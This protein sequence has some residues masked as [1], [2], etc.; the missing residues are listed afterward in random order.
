MP[1]PPAELVSQISE[2]KDEFYR[3]SVDHPWLCLYVPTLG[4]AREQPFLGEKAPSRYG[5]NEWMF[6]DPHTGRTRKVLIAW[7]VD[8]PK[9]GDRMA[10][11]DHV[12][13]LTHQAED[14]LKRVLKYDSQIS[15]EEQ[16]E[17]REWEIRKRG[18]G[19]VQWICYSTVVRYFSRIENYRQIAASALLSL[20]EKCRRP[21]TTAKARGQASAGRG[22][23]RRTEET[24]ARQKEIA[25]GWE[26][27]YES[28]AWV[29]PRNRG[30][31]TAKQ[32]FCKSEGID[33][34]TLETAL[35]QNR[36]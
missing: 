11:V 17:I 25:D 9:D 1:P 20:K 4:N 27:Y 29:E 33:L 36:R 22:R 10:V 13:G 30:E 2:L 14:L 23:R 7:G 18:Y 32:L 35:R 31:G 19:W 28:K 6:H 26:R 24:K 3:Y 34:G 8:T 16:Q 15:P 12:N 5:A 21:P